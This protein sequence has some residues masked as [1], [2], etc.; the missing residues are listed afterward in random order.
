VELLIGLDN[1]QWLPAHVE[2]SWDPDDDMRLMRSVFGHRYMITDGWG[3]DLLPPDNALGSQAGAQGGAAEQADAAQE[4]Q[5]PEYRGWS[6][7]TGN[8]GNG[9]GSGAAA[10]GGGCLGARPKIRRVAPSQ[11]TPP[12]GGG[13]LRGAG[14][15]DLAKNPVTLQRRRS[16]SEL[17]TPRPREG[18]SQDSEWCRPREGDPLRAPHPLQDED[19]GTGSGRSEGVEGNEAPAGDSPRTGHRPQTQEGGGAHCS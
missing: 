7:G 4:V 3:R 17:H 9:S 12:P 8:P 18:R 10:P 11:V 5:L 1:K 19:P 16:A 6:Q 2:D 15:E 14:R 13:W